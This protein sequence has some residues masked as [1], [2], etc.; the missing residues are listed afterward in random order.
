[1]GSIKGELRGFRRFASFMYDRFPEVKHFTEISRDMIED[2]LVYIKTDTGLTSVSYTTELSVLDNLLDEIGRELEIENI[3]NLFLS[4][5]CRA[6]DN[7]LP[8]AYSDAEIRRF[9][10]ALTKLK[11]QLG[12]CLIIH[13]MLGTRIEDTLTLRRDC[14]SEKSGHYFITIIQQKTRKYKRPVSNQ[15]AELIRKAIEVSEKEHPDSE[16]IFAR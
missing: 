7:A 15:L 10:C 8:E 16:Y 9:N 1:M 12:R 14:L 6:Y 11:P 5:D 3:C 4:S 13:Q 2:Y